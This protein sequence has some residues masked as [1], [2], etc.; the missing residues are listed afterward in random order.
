[1][2]CIFDMSACLSAPDCPT[3]LAQLYGASTL[4]CIPRLLDLNAGIYTRA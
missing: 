4:I 1:M 2:S 3:R